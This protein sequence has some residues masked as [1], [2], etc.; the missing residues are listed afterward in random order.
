MSSRKAAIKLDNFI[1]HIFSD[2]EPHNVEEVVRRARI[3]YDKATGLLNG[4]VIGSEQWNKML[5]ND[6]SIWYIKII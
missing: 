1:Q 5:R 3:S 6:N 4:K 2:G